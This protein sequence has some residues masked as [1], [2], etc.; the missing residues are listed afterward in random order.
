MKGLK[1]FVVISDRENE[2]YIIDFL[3][4]CGIKS[5]R[6]Q[7]CN[8][9]ASQS[10]LD[11]LGLVK[12][13]KIMIECMVTSDKTEQL[14]SAF[15]YGSELSGSGKCFAYFMPVDSIG[16]ESAK[17]YFI[18][19]SSIPDTEDNMDN[20]TKYVLIEVIVD[21]GTVDDV[22]AVAREAGATGGTVVKAKGTGAEIAK[23]FG[24]TI[25]EEKEI[26]NIVTKRELRDDIMKAIMKHCGKDSPSH[27]I[28]FA[29]PVESVVGVK[30][31]EG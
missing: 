23:L 22:M 15:L 25:S 17:K 12:T 19:D 6:G 2:E 28:V 26:I 27:G 31:F 14:K 18:G 1:Y 24:I 21:K 3:H 29:L 4:D 16:G 8:G 30:G 20:L 5:V 9:T 13:Q 11:Y 10:M 7:Y